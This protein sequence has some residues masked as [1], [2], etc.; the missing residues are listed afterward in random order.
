MSIKEKFEKTRQKFHK[1][2]DGLA[3]GVGY[4]TVGSFVDGITGND[5]TDW[6]LKDSAQDIAEM[7]VVGGDTTRS[8]AEKGLKLVSKGFHSFG[9]IIGSSEKDSN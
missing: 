2:K 5:S 7:P 9:K 3:R 1:A 6:H 4:A 8:V